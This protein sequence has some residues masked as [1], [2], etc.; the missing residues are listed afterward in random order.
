MWK[1]NRRRHTARTPTLDLM[2]TYSSD[3]KLVLVGDATMSPYEI[4][5]VGG[6]VEHMNQEPGAIWL[7]R[8]LQVYPY[9]IWLNPQPANHVGIYTEH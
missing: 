2:H 7:Q 1:D 6:S 5:H 9:A 8:L 4:T 3:Y